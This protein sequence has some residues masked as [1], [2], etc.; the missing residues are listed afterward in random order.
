VPSLTE[1]DLSGPN[2]VQQV[3]SYYKPND[4]RFDVFRGVLRN[5]SNYANS[6]Q[7]VQQI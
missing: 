6:A 2:E 1:I 4:I 3:L 7:Q 5:A